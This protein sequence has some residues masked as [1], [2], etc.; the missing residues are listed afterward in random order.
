MYVFMYVCMYV[1]T[2]LSGFWAAGLTC[3]TPALCLSSLRVMSTSQPPLPLSLWGWLGPC[4]SPQGELEK[5]P[6]W[7]PIFSKTISRSS[8]DKPSVALVP[9]LCLKGGLPLVKRPIMYLV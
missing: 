6:H 5:W 4:C 2:S 3:E 8:Q 1:C 7:V 9:V